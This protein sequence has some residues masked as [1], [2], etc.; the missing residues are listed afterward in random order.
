MLKEYNKFGEILITY[1]EK[2]QTLKQWSTQLNINHDT[3]YGR[4]FNQHW[5][6]ER[7][8]T[9]TNFRMARLKGIE[10]STLKFVSNPKETIFDVEHANQGDYL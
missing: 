7:A 4:L 8:F 6:V 9:S 1:K 5:P 2:T 10:A 3:L